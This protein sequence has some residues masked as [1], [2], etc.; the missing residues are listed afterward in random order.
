M[1]SFVHYFTQIHIQ[2]GTEET[3]EQKKNKSFTSKV[4]HSVLHFGGG[5]K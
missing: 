2:N 5:K 3:K 1:Q 4:F